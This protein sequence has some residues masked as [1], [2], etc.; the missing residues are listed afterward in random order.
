MILRSR[1]VSQESI[2]TDVI[3]GISYRGTPN[4]TLQLN[5]GLA[6]ITEPVGHLP[7]HNVE[8]RRLGA[9]RELLNVA[10]ADS[11]DWW[12]GAQ[13]PTEGLSFPV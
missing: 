13:K 7:G 6:E 1:D 4:A 10:T 3:V 8:S 9:F 2:H 12:Q 5:P 11:N